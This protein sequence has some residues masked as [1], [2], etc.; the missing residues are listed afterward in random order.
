MDVPD[1]FVERMRAATEGIP[2]EEKKARRQ[3]WLAEGVKITVELIEQLHQIDGVA[4]VHI[5]SIEWE[6]GVGIIAER[7]GLLPRPTV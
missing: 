5:M 7:A 2:K 6:E 1:V 4:G 3:A